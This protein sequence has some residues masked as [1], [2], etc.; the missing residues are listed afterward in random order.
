MILSAKDG[1]VH[2]QHNIPYTIGKPHPEGITL[3][4]KGYKWD[5][6]SGQYYIA[7]VDPS[8]DLV[9]IYYSDDAGWGL[10]MYAGCHTVEVPVDV[11][12]CYVAG[13]LCILTGKTQYAKY[14]ENNPD[15]VDLVIPEWAR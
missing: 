3:L 10:N 12:D 11:T 2:V 9:T 7:R 5:Y 13:L 14:C 4:A 15:D 1:E 6:R 8:P